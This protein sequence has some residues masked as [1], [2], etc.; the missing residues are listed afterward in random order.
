M[1]FFFWMGGCAIL[2]AGEYISIQGVITIT[3]LTKI[4][5]GGNPTRKALLAKANQKNAKPDFVVKANQFIDDK[6]SLSS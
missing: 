1:A 5:Q 3:L 6:K 2:T 4:E